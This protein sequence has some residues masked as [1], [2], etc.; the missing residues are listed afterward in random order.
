MPAWL[1]PSLS[2]GL[3]GI[4]LPSRASRASGLTWYGEA[5]GSAEQPWGLGRAPIPC[6]RSVQFSRSVLSDCDP[7]TAARQ[8]SLSLL[9]GGGEA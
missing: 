9:P 4:C 7:L 8:A 1:S 6:P 3:C 5:L 2:P